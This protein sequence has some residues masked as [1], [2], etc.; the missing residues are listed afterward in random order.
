MKQNSMLQHFVETNNGT[1]QKIIFPEIADEACYSPAPYEAGKSLQVL[2]RQNT[3]YDNNPGTEISKY[4][5]KLFLV[6]NG[7]IS[8]IESPV[9]KLKTVNKKNRPFFNVNLKQ[10]PALLSNI[11]LAIDNYDAITFHASVHSIT[12]L[13]I[14][15]NMHA[16]IRITHQMEEL[17]AENKMLDVKDQLNRIKKII[18][19]LV[20]SMQYIKS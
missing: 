5:S 15:M 1:S 7:L 19:Q 11:E 12:D 18:A 8:G 20:Q 9:K 13:F 6:K 10:I 4:E 17:A 2:C 3:V 14:D 16:A